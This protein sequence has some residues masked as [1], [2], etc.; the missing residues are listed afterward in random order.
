[1]SRTLYTLA[2][3]NI[4]IRKCT[5]AH[6]LEVVTQLFDTV[7]HNCMRETYPLLTRERVQIHR[8]SLMLACRDITA[9]ITLLVVRET[10]AKGLL[11]C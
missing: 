2:Y 7:A 5:L 8:P 6:K 3:T 10:E 4:G 1:M 9:K 11:R